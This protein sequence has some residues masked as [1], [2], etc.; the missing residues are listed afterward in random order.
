MDGVW[1][2]PDEEADEGAPGR[3]PEPREERYALDLRS[4]PS[5]ALE[6]SPY[7]V[8]LLEKE[9]CLA[10]APPDLGSRFAVE[11]REYRA[12]DEVVVY[13]W[14]VGADGR[15]LGVRNLLPPERLVQA[16]HA[17]GWP[18]VSHES[19][20][21]RIWFSEERGADLSQ[22]V[23]RCVFADPY[24]SEDGRLAL[25]YDTYELHQDE[26]ERLKGFPARWLEVKEIQP[27]GQ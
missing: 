1:V 22:T 8:V 15:L 7:L 12:M 2:Y 4:P 18:Y 11:G 13:D 21:L 5:P 24:R 10:L 9:R 19:D 26:I 6:A 3:P 17:E 16:H 27:T 20:E 25:A 23:H 14:M